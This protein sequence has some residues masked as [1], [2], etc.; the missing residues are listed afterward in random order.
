MKQITPEEM[1]EALNQKYG[2]DAEYD[3]GGLLKVISAFTT[4][5][6]KEEGK[7]SANITEVIYG[8]G[9]KFTFHII[10]ERWGN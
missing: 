6:M 8:E 10:A 9:L 7:I 1:I 3:I 2:E 5:C 4:R